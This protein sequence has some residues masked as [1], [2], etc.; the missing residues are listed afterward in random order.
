M[1]STSYEKVVDSQAPNSVMESQTPCCFTNRLSSQ[2]HLMGSTPVQQKQTVMTPRYLNIVC[3][4]I[5]VP[6]ELNYHIVAVVQ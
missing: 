4:Q 3:L 1:D 5:N 6:N 2:T